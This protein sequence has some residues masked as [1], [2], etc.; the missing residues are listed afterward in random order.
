MDTAGQN[1]IHSRWVTSDD[2]LINVDG[3]PSITQCGK[4]G[5]PYPSDLS[6]TLKQI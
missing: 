5:S 1:D 2:G 4:D 3:Y 6:T